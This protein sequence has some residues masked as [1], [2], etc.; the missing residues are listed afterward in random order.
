MNSSSSK[1]AIHY[2]SQR[3]ARSAVVI[4]VEMVTKRFRL[5]NAQNAANDDWQMIDI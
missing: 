3:R 4:V 2:N 5:E 1:Y